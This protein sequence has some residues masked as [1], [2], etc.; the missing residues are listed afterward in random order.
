MYLNDLKHQYVTIFKERMTFSIR[1]GLCHAVEQDIDKKLVGFIGGCDSSI[2][3]TEYEKWNEYVD[4]YC[5]FIYKY[6]TK[7][8]IDKEGCVIEVFDFIVDKNIA[9]KGIG[10]KLFNEWIKNENVKKFK[11]ILIAAESIFT[12][13]ICQ[14]HD[15]EILS[16]MKYES[17]VTPDG[18][19]PFLDHIKCLEKN[20]LS[21][22]HTESTVLHLSMA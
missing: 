8:E 20:G 14:K 9:S 6:W 16:R 5:D 22:I 15:F 4:A 18:K 7:Y 13:K 19:T 2:K 3:T 21:K 10:S 12:V 11:D 1:N 17:M